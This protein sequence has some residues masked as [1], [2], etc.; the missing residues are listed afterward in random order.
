VLKSAFDSITRRRLLANLQPALRGLGP[1]G[2]PARVAEHRSVA[3]VD[4]AHE[5]AL[6]PFRC[7]DGSHRLSAPSRRILAAD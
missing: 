4:E 6:A 7:D 1:A 2:V 3:A 5:V